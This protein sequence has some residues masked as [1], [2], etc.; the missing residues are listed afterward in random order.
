MKKKTYDDV[1][2]RKQ[3]DEAVTELESLLWLIGDTC[4]LDY[5]RW[6]LLREKIFRVNGYGSPKW[7][8]PAC[9][10]ERK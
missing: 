4:D 8:G 7:E 6:N 3:W 2:K 10:E 1:V 5:Q 9:I